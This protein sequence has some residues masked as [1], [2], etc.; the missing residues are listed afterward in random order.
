MA[1][2]FLQ[3]GS[4]MGGN[5]VLEGEFVQPEFFSQLVDCA[6]VGRTQFDPDEIGGIADV[7]ADILQRNGAEGVGVK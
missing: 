1:A 6:A 5:G 2:I 7:F 4:L 3:L